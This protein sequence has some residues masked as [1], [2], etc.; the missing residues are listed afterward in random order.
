MSE[1]L[2]AKVNARR[3]AEMVANLRRL[4]RPNGANNRGNGSQP[5]RQASTAAVAEEHCD[6]CGKP[7]DH[8]H[9]HLLHLVD[10]RILCTCE[11]C[12]AMRGGDAE[13]RPTGTRTLWLDDFDLPD[14]IWASFG[15]PIGLAF[16]IDS[17]VTGGIAALYPSPAGAT[18]SEIEPLVWN[19]LRTQNPV[20]MGLELDAEALIVNRMVDPPL[21]AIAPIDEC[22]RLV[23]LVKVNWD[24]ISGGAGL[25]RAISGF[26]DELQQAA[27]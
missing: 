2:D 9:R 10:R 16:F 13:L 24:G 21:H 19:R 20:L 8:D 15:I 6:L 26:F 7:I 3:Q 12:L 22:Y 4:A 17:T 18:E 5:L 25:E 14:E 1:A 27:Q 11:S 23:G